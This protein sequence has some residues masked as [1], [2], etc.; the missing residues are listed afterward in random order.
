MVRARTLRHCW[1]SPILF[2]SIIALVSINGQGVRPVGS[3]IVTGATEGMAEGEGDSEGRGWA[4]QRSAR[5]EPSQGF[6]AIEL[7]ASRYGSAIPLRL[8]NPESRSRSS[9]TFAT[10]AYGPSRD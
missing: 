6:T 5:R 9:H 8:P 1:A 4:Q 7:E 3:S 2:G 10:S